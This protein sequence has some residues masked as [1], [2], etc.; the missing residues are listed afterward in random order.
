M[1]SNKTSST[2]YREFEHRSD[3]TKDYKMCICCFS[4]KDAAWRTDWFGAW[5]MC[6]GKAMY[7]SANGCC[8][9]LA[10][11][12][13]TC[14][15]NTRQILSSKRNSLSPQ[16]QTLSLGVTQQS[17]TPTR[18]LRRKFVWEQHKIHYDLCIICWIWD[19]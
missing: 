7:L 9:E 6:P 2:V 3:Q 18:L 10:W 12:N 19:Q 4:A 11:S 8:S 5:I 14:W 15:S 13:S 17:L 16:L 1:V